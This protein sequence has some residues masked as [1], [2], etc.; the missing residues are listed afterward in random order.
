MTTT[1]RSHKAKQPAAP[2]PYDALPINPDWIYRLHDGWKYF[3]FSPTQM[4]A[5]IR[6]GD[7]PQPI[8]LS[9]GGRAKGWLGST[10]LQ[11]QAER[12]AKAAQRKTTR[13]AARS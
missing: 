8:S 7:I 11:W 2:E 9:D 3:G 5:R 6:D 1:K 12:Q 10:I 4:D 13:K